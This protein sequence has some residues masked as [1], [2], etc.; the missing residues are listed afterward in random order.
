MYPS[1]RDLPLKTGHDQ[2]HMVSAR[3]LIRVSRNVIFLG[4]TSMFTDISS[5]MVGAILPLYL[6]FE[7]GLTAL[8]FGVFD[9]LYQG[10]TALV[11]LAGGLAADR[12]GRYKEVAGVGY[13]LST[14]CKLALL[15]VGTAWIPTVTALFIDRLGKGLRTPPRDA[16]IAV[17]STEAN[18]AEAFG[19][20]RAFDTTGALIGPLVAFAL[21]R[22]VPG[23]Y[24]VLF[25][26]SFLA[27]LIGLTVLVL[28]VEGKVAVSNCLR[29]SAPPSLRSAITQLSTPSFRR[30]VIAGVLLSL[31]SLSDAFI[32]LAINRRSALP[33]NTFPLLYV[34][35][36][37]AYLILAIPVGRLADRLGRSSVFLG[38][39]LLLLGV[40]GFLLLP[41]ISLTQF[42]GC[43][44]LLGAYYAATD[45]VLMALAST[46][47]AQP[48]LT[49]GLALL[50]TATAMARFLS[51]VCFGAIWN[52]MGLESALL[53]FI[54]GLVAASVSSTWIFT[55]EKEPIGA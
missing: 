22:L 23:N 24:E 46:T 50:T 31:M 21:L 1:V 15:A 53:V 9:G 45:G 51:A 4:L 25:A 54:V 8:Q 18:R 39:H 32:Y 7:L 6:T 49:S 38:G 30:L 10:I 42:I 16:L 5:E 36:A 55:L 48:S 17:H 43:L 2:F 35:T 13:A 40:Y 19:V 12:H 11:R 44:V 3:R 34:C 14:G 37:L 47:L 28:F 20:H 33:P 29:L 27:G 41:L 26:G 52:W